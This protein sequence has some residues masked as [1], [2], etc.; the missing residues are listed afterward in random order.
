MLEG[1]GLVF[2]EYKMSDPRGAIARKSRADEPRQR[3]AVLFAPMTAQGRQSS[4][5][6][7]YAQRG[8][9]NVESTRLAPA[10]LT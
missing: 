6:K 5:E 8:S 9:R 1:G 2:L 7:G 3:G 10:M 4:C